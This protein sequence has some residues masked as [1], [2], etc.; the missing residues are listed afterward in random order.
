MTQVLKVD[1]LSV[2]YRSG[3]S[4]VHAVR[5]ASLS[6]GRAE[7][8][9]VVGESGSGKSTVARAVLGLLP[10]NARITEGSI[11][12]E[13]R[14]VTH[15][16]PE[17]RRRT[18]G[19]PATMVFQDPLSYLNPVMRVGEQIAEGVRLHDQEAD[20]AGRVKELLGM[21]QLPKEVAR[22]YPHEL[23]GGMRQRVMIAIALGCRPK[24]LIADE[25]TTALDVVTQASVLDLLRRIQAEIGLAVLFISHDLAVVANL[26]DRVYVMYSGTTVES[27]PARDLVQAPGHPYTYGLVSAAMVRRDGSGGFST[28]PGEVPDLSV[29]GPGCPF[30]PRCPE[31]QERCQAQAPPLVAVGDRR[32]VRCWLHVDGRRR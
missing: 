15:L 22:S 5:G 9:G 11:M 30:A 3:G 10:G 18:R 12:L 28:I 7:F 21:V 31:A 16:Q 26:V 13:G 6:V 1:R 2:T 17:E 19:N 32:T 4:T 20:V 27:A 23:S 29:I 24:L 8:V 14:D 25:P